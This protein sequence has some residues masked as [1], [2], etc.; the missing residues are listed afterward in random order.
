ME[1]GDKVFK[2]DQDVLRIQSQEETL[3]SMDIQ[4][5]SYKELIQS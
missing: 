2:V 3:V 1:I 5:L 4:F